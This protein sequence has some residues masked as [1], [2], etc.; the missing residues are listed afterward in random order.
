MLESHGGHGQLLTQ[1]AADRAVESF[2]HAIYDGKSGRQDTEQPW[3][4]RPCLGAEVP[5]GAGCD[6]P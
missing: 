4:I 1:F 2:R 6:R 3:F 5:A